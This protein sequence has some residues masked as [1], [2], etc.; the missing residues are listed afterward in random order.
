[1]LLR[2]FIKIF[3]LS[4]CLVLGSLFYFFTTEWFDFSVLENY[5][6][7][8][9]SIV[10]D[11]NNK[12]I[13]RFELEYDK[14]EHITSDKLPDI[15]VKAFIAAEDRSFFSHYGISLKGLLRSF[16]VNLYHMRY[17]QGASTITQQLVRVFFLSNERKIVRKLK[18]VFL[19]LAL[20]RKFSKEQILE[21]YINNIY[22]GRGIYG[23]E[24]ACRRFWNKSAHE[25]NAKEAATLAAVA[26][27]AYIYSPLNSPLTS[28]KRRNI[29]LR[30]MYLIGYISEEE[31]EEYKNSNLDLCDKIP[32]NPMRLYIQEWIRGWVENEWGRDVLYK[33][34]LKIKT[35]IDLDAQK[36]AEKSFEPV[37]RKLRKTQGKSLNGGM[38]SIEAHTGKIR[39]LIGGL[40]FNESQFNRG[41]QAVRQ[42][43]SS[44]KP[45][46]YAAAIQAGYSFDSTWIDEP[47]E[48]T[49]GREIWKP[50]NWTRRFDGEMTL[51]KALS[52]SNNI[53]SIKTFL[54]VGPDPIIELSKK[55]GIYRELRPYPS[56][57]LGTAEATVEENTAAFNVFASNGYYTKPFLI[58]YVRDQW[59]KKVWSGEPYKVKVLDSVTNSKMI[60]AL[61]LF[62]KRRKLFLNKE[63]WL[64][65]EVIGK[66][67]STN[68]STTNWYVGSNPELT[69][70][71]YIGRDDSK[72][73]GGHV[74]SN[75]TTYPI[76]F[77]FNKSIKCA[78]KT[79]YT[80]PSLRE[81]SINWITGEASSEDSV[82][83]VSIL[84]EA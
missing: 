45:I 24:A 16:L 62:M 50:R 44:F 10:L 73:M 26:K 33:K 69:T 15:L 23:V 53:V 76:W 67:G 46:V 30:S 2:F 9:P 65:V 42:T 17:I 29:I 79:F 75:Q 61:S 11:A 21:L 37:V 77:N 78:K 84:K 58:E 66:T 18:E 1:M 39:A 20:E 63:H 81:C 80:D 32:G 12:E 27:S 14:R 72:P 51:V 28:K 25:V 54:K 83:T 41:F 60:N 5:D 13:C 82:D 34:G 49:L 40:D 35:T 74:F 4:A 22:F 57:S 59:G 19:S 56:L 3:I 47:L 48:M 70:A 8:K 68:D 64:D 52:T 7:G 6:P 71:V 38:I 36:Y 31:F 43:G 55:F